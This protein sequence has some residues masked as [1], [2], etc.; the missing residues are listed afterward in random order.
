MKSTVSTTISLLFIVLFPLFSAASPSPA[1]PKLQSDS[2]LS[3]AGYYRLTW[4]SETAG[5]FELEEAS[6][7][8]FA[9]AVNLYRGPDTATLIS[10]RADGV[11]YYRIR[12]IHDETD[13]NWSNVTRVEV[14]H[15]P[16]SRA[17]MFFALG[18]LVFV[19]TLI[20]VIHGNK[21]HKH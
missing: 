4:Q 10:G 20:V 17:F 7:P 18:A 11:Y 3:T 21:S 12:N 14:Q 6:D 13:T 19:A 15:H 1:A 2:D 9:Q 8:A 5:D 16:L